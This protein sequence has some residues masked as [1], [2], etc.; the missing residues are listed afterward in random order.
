M[1]PPYYDQL[2]EWTEFVPESEIRRLLLIQVK[3]YFGG[4]KPGSLPIGT[5]QKILYQIAEEL[6]TEGLDI[7]NYGPTGGLPSLKK[8]LGN[9]IKRK[10]NVILPNGEDDILISTGSQQMLYGLLDVLL[11]PKD[12]IV[13]ARPSYLGFV[14]PVTK[15]GGEVL[16][17]P[18]DMNGLIPEYVEKAIIISERE[19]KRTPKAVY[20]VSDSDNPKGTTISEKRRKELFN[21]ATQHEIL[22]IEDSAY[23]EIQFTKIPDPIKSY[24]KEN[25]WVAYLRT[26]SKEAA[27]LRLGYSVLPEKLMDP[28]IKDKG[29]LD[30]CTPSLNQRILDIYYSNYIDKVLGDILR[31]YKERR[32]V[33]QKVIDD[34]FP[35][36]G[37]R[38]NPTGGFFFWYMLNNEHFDSA[39]FMQ[40]VAIPNEVVYV[41]GQ[42]FYPIR[43]YSIS[44]NDNELHGNR[45]KTNGMRLSY[46]Y[47][48]PEIIQEGM[49][50]LGKLLQQV[51]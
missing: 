34:F 31:V 24:D 20:V 50:R 47:T 18:S 22:I 4:G 11:R 19:L 28:M 33:M 42:S 14:V 5:F 1:T 3:Y 10:D 25:E 15:L 49:E 45:I 51:A 44:K 12:V 2:A 43:G 41:P 26:S 38:T 35:S 6:E 40:D 7:L 16:S 17:V 48:T 23:R 46:S 13:M 27:V 32:D 8:T 36:D 29:Y 37:S 39:K 21:I 9:R 30:L